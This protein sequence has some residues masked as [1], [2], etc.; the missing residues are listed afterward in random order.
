MFFGI[1]NYCRLH[2]LVSR[3]KLSAVLFQEMLSR[4]RNFFG[5]EQRTFRC[6]RS[7]NLK[8]HREFFVRGKEF[9]AALFQRNFKYIAY[10]IFRPGANFLL[11]S[12][13][14]LYKSD[15]I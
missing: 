6:D 14:F 15:V 7:K 13:R 9:S 8:S 3:S 4:R 11:R 5:H 2:F 12:H 1:Q 10:G